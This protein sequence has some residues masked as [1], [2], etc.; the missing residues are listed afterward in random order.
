MQKLARQQIKMIGQ[1]LIR[2]LRH[3]FILSQCVF[4]KV[5]KVLRDESRRMTNNIAAANT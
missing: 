3:D 4:W 1:K 5:F 2:M